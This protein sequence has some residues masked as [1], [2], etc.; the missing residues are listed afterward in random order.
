MV[1]IS[2]LPYKKRFDCSKK[3]C[4][5]KCRGNRPYCKTHIINTDSERNSYIR[6]L[7]EMGSNVEIN[8]DDPIGWILW[9]WNSVRQ[10]LCP[11]R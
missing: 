9:C 6:A 10:G 5:E 7:K 11:Y 3:G 4:R 2:T 8:K 1:K